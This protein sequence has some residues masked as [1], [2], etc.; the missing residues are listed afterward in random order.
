MRKYRIMFENEE[1]GLSL[2]IVVDLTANNFEEA[3]TKG[4]ESILLA[5]RVKEEGIGILNNKKGG[6]I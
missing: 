6:T 1:Y 4:R 2:P 5:D 3:L